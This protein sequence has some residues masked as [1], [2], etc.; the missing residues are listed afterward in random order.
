ML[1]ALEMAKRFSAH[2][3]FN[4]DLQLKSVR[5]AGQNLLPPFYRGGK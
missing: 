2:A 4:T 3:S 5:Q 1:N